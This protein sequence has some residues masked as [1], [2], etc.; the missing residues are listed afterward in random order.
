MFPSMFSR[1]P[2]S[3]LFVTAVWHEKRGGKIQLVLPPR[4]ILGYQSLMINTR[5]VHRQ[6]DVFAVGLVR[7][8]ASEQYSGREETQ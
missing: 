6:G 1:V 3:V 8:A 2:G 4:S 7:T 5:T